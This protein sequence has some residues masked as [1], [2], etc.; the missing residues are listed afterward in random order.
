MNRPMSRRP[1]FGV[2]CSPAAE[3]TT[4]PPTDGRANAALVKLLA[5]ALGVAPSA[6]SLAAGA[7]SKVKTFKVDGLDESEVRARLGG[8]TP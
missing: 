4:A 7:A 5:K 3:R 8:P 1:R 2:G 6:V